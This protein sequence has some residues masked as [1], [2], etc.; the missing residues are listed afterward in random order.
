M[1]L[2]RAKIGRLRKVKT[3]IRGQAIVRYN[4]RY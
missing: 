4:E 2:P 3:I 1:A